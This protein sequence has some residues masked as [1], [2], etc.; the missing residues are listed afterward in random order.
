[1][2]LLKKYSELIKKMWYYYFG[3]SM[4]FYAIK[5]ENAS[6]IVDS[7]DEAQI[8]IK[9][10][11]KPKYKSF[12]S[13]EE[14]KAFIS[15]DVIKNKINGPVAYIDGSY[16]DINGEYSFGC[17]LLVDGKEYTFNKKYE[18][19]EYSN[20]RNVSGEI[21]GAG[22]IIQYAINRGFKSLDIFYDYI[23]IEK[24]FMH[25]WKANS[26]IAIKYVEFADKIRNKIK[27]TFHKVK[28]HTND[29]YNDMADSLAKRALGI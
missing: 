27:I 23:G 26:E 6:F 20:S 2:L 1:M 11:I 7:W 18:A 29:H 5:G 3:D 9:E 19:D 22:F 16:N 25:E 13:L 17:V 14:A 28:S 4:K 10:C 21:K 15:G 24:W 8:K 12:N